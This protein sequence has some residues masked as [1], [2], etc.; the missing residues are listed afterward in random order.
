MKSRFIIIPF[1]L[2]L[3]LIWGRVLYLQGS[4]YYAGRSFGEQK[5]WK[6]AIREYD[7][8]LHFYAPFSPFTDKAALGLWNIGRTFEDEGRLDWAQLAYSSLRSGF[9]GT[10]SFYTPGRQWIEK[11][12][13]KIADL[14]TRML[15]AEGGVKPEDAALERQKQLGV[16]RDDRAPSVFWSFMAE[17]GFFG[18]VI[19]AVLLALEG[20]EKTGRLRRRPAIFWALSF[21]A[22]ALVWAVS[23]L[24]A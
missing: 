19:S 24:R 3:A 18:W 17:L 4:H 23:L 6:L 14:N 11:C 8:S 10:R 15:L 21:L 7:T 13:L 2:V 22:C 5:D 12:D 9:Y 1:L 20:F 16:L